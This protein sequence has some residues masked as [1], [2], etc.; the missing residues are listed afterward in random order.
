M[1]PL[2]LPNATALEELQKVHPFFEIDRQDLLYNGWLFQTSYLQVSGE[3][4]GEPEVNKQNH[5]CNC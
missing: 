3:G 5:G 2:F 4:E 1:N